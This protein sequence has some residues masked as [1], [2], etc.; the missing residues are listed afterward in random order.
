MTDYYSFAKTRALTSK[1]LL[2]IIVAACVCLG[3]L[4]IYLNASVV[5]ANAAAKK[6]EKKYKVTVTVNMGKN[7]S[8]CP[9]V[10]FKNGSKT[11]AIAYGKTFTTGGKSF[12]HKTKKAAWYKENKVK[13]VFTSVDLPKGKYKVTV[14]NGKKTKTLA[15]SLSITK[16]LKKSYTW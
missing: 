15:K 14:D 7:G 10:Y 5:D 3:S 9:V 6:E 1:R 4:F 11:T 8:D 2:S 12:K 16:A 13:V